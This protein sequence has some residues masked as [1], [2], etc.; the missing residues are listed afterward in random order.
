[1][2]KFRAVAYETVQVRV[3]KYYFA[4]AETEME[5]FEKMQSGETYRE[6][7]I[8]D[9]AEARTILSREVDE[10]SFLELG[11]T[12]TVKEIKQAVDQGKT[13]HW[14][15]NMYQVVKDEH[16]QYLVLAGFGSAL[17]DLSTNKDGTIGLTWRDGTVLN[18]KEEDFFLAEEDFSPDRMTLKEIKQAVDQGKTVHWKDQAYRVVKNKGDYFIHCR[19]NGFTIGLTWQD[20]QTLNGKPEDF[21][22]AGKD[23]R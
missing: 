23:S 8:Y 15:T 18:G 20:G 4:E 3:K 17:I 14:K 7:T 2:P 13:V 9:D 12:M 1:M 16:D 22:L 5:A 19:L 11:K 21:F 10:K 6:E